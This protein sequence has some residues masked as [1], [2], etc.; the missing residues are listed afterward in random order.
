VL[1]PLARLPL[2]RHLVGVLSFA[3][4]AL[5]VLLWVTLIHLFAIGLLIPSDRVYGWVERAVNKC[6]S[7]WVSTNDWWFRHMLGLRWDLDTNL[8]RDFSRPH[9]L[10]ANHRSW[11]DVFLILSQMNGRLT[12]PRVFMKSSLRWL[13]LIGSAT[14]IM[15]FPQVKRY[16]KEL[17]AKKPHLAGK[18]LQTTRKAC[19][20]FKRYPNNLLSFVEGTRFTDKKHQQQQSPYQTLLK[21]RARGIAY[22]LE[23]LPGHFDHIVDFT[24]Y[25]PQAQ[26]SFW[27]LLT[28]RLQQATIRVHTVP[29]PTQFQ[30]LDFH[31]AEKDKPVFFAWFNQYW[32][33][34]DQ[35]LLALQHKSCLLDS[36]ENSAINDTHP[37]QK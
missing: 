20:R 31:P 10:I 30:Q 26:H 29:L 36:T 28:G 13:P 2:L 14:Y 37:T 32:T 9:L 6:F 18:D 4:V 24:I 16:S 23:A 22:V 35:R 5:N 11:V 7:N 8:E 17:I 33:E 34:K 3:V 12:L 19:E 1:Q 15:G 21:P 25:Y 27:D